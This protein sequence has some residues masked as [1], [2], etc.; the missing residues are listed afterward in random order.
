MKFTIESYELKNALARVISVVER[1]AT[2]QII[3]YTLFEI[4]QDTLTLSA[5]DCEVFARVKSNVNSQI[6]TKFC[7]NAKNL[8]E[9]LNELK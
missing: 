6:N 2:N 3:G 5:T 4:D 8:F 9:I 7:V 1:K